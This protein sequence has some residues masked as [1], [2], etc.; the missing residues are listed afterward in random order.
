MTDMSG[1]HIVCFGNPLHG[2]DGFGSAVFDAL[3]SRTLPEDVRLVDGGTS[4]LSAINL[5]ED[6]SYAILVDAIKCDQNLGE[7]RWLDVSSVADKQSNP[8][9]SHALGIP[10]ILEGIR[11]L[12]EEGEASPE[13][14]I[15]TCNIST[16]TQFK[17]ELSPAVENAIETAVEQIL[18]KLK[19]REND[20]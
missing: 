5:F 10:A 12:E 17:F 11:I 7:V 14:D 8:L 16:P 19:G 2:D 4:S 1:R 13:L 3:Q 6:C 9:S 18:L 15:L 20:L